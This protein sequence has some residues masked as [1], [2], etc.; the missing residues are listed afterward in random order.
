MRVVIRWR[1]EAGMSAALG[2]RGWLRV[3]SIVAHDALM[4]EQGFDVVCDV[5]SGAVRNTSP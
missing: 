1:S 5:S 3:P 4:R 2:I